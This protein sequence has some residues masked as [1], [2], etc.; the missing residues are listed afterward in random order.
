MYTMTTEVDGNDGGGSAAAA[1]CCHGDL[2]DDVT[3]SHWN[4]AAVLGRDTALGDAEKAF[5]AFRFDESQR[6]TEV[7]NVASTTVGKVNL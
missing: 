3:S 4:A 2:T 5:L 6:M 7:E 1:P